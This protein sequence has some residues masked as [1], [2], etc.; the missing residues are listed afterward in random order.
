VTRPATVSELN[1]GAEK[2][3]SE[4]TMLHPNLAAAMVAALGELDV[5]VK[6]RTAD[7]GSYSY[8][9]A[10]LADIVSETTPVLARHG[11]AARTPVHAYGDGLAVSVR[12]LH[13]SGEEHVDEPLPFPRGANAQ[14][15]GSAITYFRRYALLAS[16]NLATGDD[17]DG[18]KAAH[19]A[20]APDPVQGFRS[21]L[22]D[23][24]NAL[25]PAELK[26]VRVWL[27]EQGLPVSPAQMTADQ[28]D[29]ACEY[30]LHGLPKIE[31]DGAGSGD[32]S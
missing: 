13:T 32:D 30:I 7:A 23:A 18:A 4:A 19:A 15:T 2:A 3:A 6:S 11:L 28:A 8:D 26:A 22:I 17:D 16:L 29:R 20:A 31:P 14:A 9:Y 24:M 25:T 10:D 1:A 27:K 5:I 21:S 12:I